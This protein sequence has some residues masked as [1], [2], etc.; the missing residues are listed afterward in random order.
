MR[1]KFDDVYSLKKQI[2]KDIIIS[3]KLL[4]HND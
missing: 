4:S 3:N 2:E 1:K